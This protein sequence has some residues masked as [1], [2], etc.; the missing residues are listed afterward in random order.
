VSTKERWELF[1][2]EWDRALNDGEKKLAYFKM[3]EANSLRGEFWKWTEEERNQ[4]LSELTYIIRKHVMFSV[5]AVLWWDSYRDIQAQYPAYPQSPY[6]ILF[7]N[8]MGSTVKH[9]MGL[10]V[11]E[12]VEFIFDEQGKEG[13]CAREAFELAKA[14][15]PSEMLSYVGYEPRHKS[16]KDFLPL[17]AADM[18]A[19]QVRRFL[20]D[21]SGR[22]PDPQ[23][24]EYS[25]TL[26]LLT[27]I[28]SEDTS[29]HRLKL[30][31]FFEGLKQAFPQRASGEIS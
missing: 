11:P 27:T 14:H 25:A 19:W 28:P 23:A 10:R 15:I 22:G 12:K 7:H 6:E 30:I 13:K 2:V 17:Q 1:A 5:S 26:N 9:I 8:V 24:Y 29:L 4:K 3:A 31:A 21:N 20:S 16:D 18:Y